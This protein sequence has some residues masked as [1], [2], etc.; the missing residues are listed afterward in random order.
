M[1]LSLII[2]CLFPPMAIVVNSL[3]SNVIFE[4][5]GTIFIMLILPCQLSTD[6]W[7]HMRNSLRSFLWKFRVHPSTFAQL[8]SKL[9]YMTHLHYMPPAIWAKV[10]WWE[11]PF[12]PH[13][14]TKLDRPELNNVWEWR[15]TYGFSSRSLCKFIR[16]SHRTLGFGVSVQ[17]S[18]L[19]ENIIADSVSPFWSWALET[20]TIKLIHC[21]WT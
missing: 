12:K 17:F 6:R 18:W 13:W 15:N 8:R 9:P 21:Y 20:L 4:A 19:W 2:R 10:T 5:R 3:E 14:E 7:P 11:Y 16:R 1:F